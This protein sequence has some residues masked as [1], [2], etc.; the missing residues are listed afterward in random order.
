M[1]SILLFQGSIG[2]EVCEKY[3]YW[4]EDS[5]SSRILKIKNIPEPKPSSI[6]PT[7]L[8]SS[9]K[10]VQMQLT[11]LLLENNTFFPHTMKSNQL[12]NLNL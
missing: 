9:N 11:E 5:L 12:L 4:K 3:I 2:L 10:L 8:N 1:V 6:K 7:H